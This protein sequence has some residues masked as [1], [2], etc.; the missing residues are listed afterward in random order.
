MK[1]VL[2]ISAIALLFGVAGASAEERAV[3]TKLVPVPSGSLIITEDAGGPGQD[4][5]I[6][7][8]AGTVAEEI[9]I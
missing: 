8:G 7:E 3:G 4:I 5:I 2:A 6:A 1:E 9:A